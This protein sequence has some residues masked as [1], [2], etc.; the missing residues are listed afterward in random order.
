[1]KLPALDEAAV[2]TSTILRMYTREAGFFAELAADAPLR[3][4]ACHHHAVDH[5]TSEFVL[6]M[7]DLG[8]PAGRRPD[9]GHG[10][11]RR[12]AGGGRHGRVARRLVAPGHPLAERRLTVRLDDDIYKAVLPM[13]FDEGWAKLTAELA[14]PDAVR[15]GR[16]PAGSAAFPAPARRPRRGADDD[17][18]R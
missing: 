6:V 7:E 4:P 2:F 10:D 8:I 18:P 1:M 16:R 13:V 14:V 15:A 12:R 11:R 17:V 5:E 9:R 3:V